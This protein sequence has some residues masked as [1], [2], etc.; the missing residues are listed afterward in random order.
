MSGTLNTA[1]ALIATR[2]H[3][4][5]QR[6]VSQGACHCAGGQGECAGCDSQPI[7]R[8]LH[9]VPG[10]PGQPGRDGLE[11]TGILKEGLPG[12]AGKMV[13]LV[14]NLDG[15][16]SEYD[17][18]WKL[19]LVSFDIEDENGDGIFE[20]GEKIIIR[21]VCVEN[22]GIVS[23]PLTFHS[24]SKLLMIISRRNAVALTR[25]RIAHKAI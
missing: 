22:I 8:S 4:R 16:I 2:Y 15:T 23:P 13:I 21:R 17:K 6:R 12:A 10:Q 3:A 14:Q 5:P 19:R 24:S 7:T 11:Q 18:P 20:P 9:R 25:N 1:V